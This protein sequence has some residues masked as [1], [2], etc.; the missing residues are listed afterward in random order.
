M[1]PGA[2]I[3][4]L[5]H[6]LLL[7]MLIDVKMSTIIGILTFISMINTT[8]SCSVELSMEKNLITLFTQYLSEY[9]EIKALQACNISHIFNAKKAF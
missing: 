8:I 5:F 4:K 6:A 7:I 9:L 2:E 3:I 1:V